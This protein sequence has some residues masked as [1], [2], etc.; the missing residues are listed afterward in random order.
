MRPA[1]LLVLALVLPACV[2]GS[3]RAGGGDLGED[4]PSEQPEHGLEEAVDIDDF[5]W[6]IPPEQVGAGSTLEGTFVCGFFENP[7]DRHFTADGELW[8][9]TTSHEA[10][11]DIGMREG[12]E[13]CLTEGAE[14]YLDW[15]VDADGTPFMYLSGGFHHDMRPT[16]T[17]GVWLGQ[18]YPVDEP[19]DDCLTALERHG[20]TLPVVLTFT[21]DAVNIVP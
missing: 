12:T 7:A 3:P 15:Y 19:S 17:E 11:G 14:K 2:A 1:P 18:V 20:L 10:L 4:E 21:V 16:I 6:A 9:E 5:A 13:A 8:Q